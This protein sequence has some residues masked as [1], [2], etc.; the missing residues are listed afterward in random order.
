MK[1]IETKVVYAIKVCNDNNAVEPV[2]GHLK[3]GNGLDR[4]YLKG[5]EGDRINTILAGCGLQFQ[6]S[7]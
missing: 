1:F 5:E 3:T 6:E 2:I 4:N 7:S